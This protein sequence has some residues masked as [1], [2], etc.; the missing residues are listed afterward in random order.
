[1]MS[2]V[3]DEPVNFHILSVHVWGMFLKYLHHLYFPYKEYHIKCCA[4]VDQC[5]ASVPVYLFAEVS[6]SSTCIYTCIPL[7]PFLSQVCPYDP[8]NHSW[9]LDELARAMQE[10][11]KK[12]NPVVQRVKIIM[13][14]GLLVVHV[15]SRF[16]SSVTGL[17][18]GFSSSSGDSVEASSVAERVSEVDGDGDLVKVPLPDYL[19]W[20][21]FHLTADQV[22]TCRFTISYM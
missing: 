15:H 17:S 13:A 4:D 5:V 6:P 22:C 10:E 14:L 8:G 12:P 2:V 9:H 21:V 3:E 18:F 20:K 7:F 11:E 16:L 1:M 19:W